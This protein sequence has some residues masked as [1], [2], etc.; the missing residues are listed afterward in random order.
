MDYLWT[1]W[2][3]R[4][5]ADA[6]KDERCIFCDA[7]AANDDVRTLILLRGEKNFVILNRYPYTSGHVMVVPY[8]HVAELA[9]AEPDTLSEMMGMAQRVQVA[10]WKTYRPHGY[11]LG[12]NL[13]SAAGAG[14]TG[15]LHLHVLP[16]WAG[17]ANFMT[18]VGE[19]RVEPEDLSTTFE[20]MRRALGN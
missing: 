9:S 8:A 19:T 12:M 4:Y 11:N 6:S 2:R 20:R 1:P 7:L 14:V 10:L 17:D 15:H 13:G 16:R 18:V 3:Y 5:V